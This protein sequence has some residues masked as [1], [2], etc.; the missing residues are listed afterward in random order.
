[1]ANARST[2]ISCSVTAQAS[3]WK[4]SAIRIGRSQG[5][6]RRIGPIR[7]SLRKRS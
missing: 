6:R 1:M 2:S 4:G 7:R 5:L 3:A